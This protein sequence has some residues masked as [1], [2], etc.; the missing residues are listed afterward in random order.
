MA[1]HVRIQMIE[2][3]NRADRSR[4]HIA[5]TF[6]AFTAD[7]AP[8]IIAVARDEIDFF[9]AITDV[10]HPECSGGAVEARAERIAE[11]HCVNL[12]TWVT[13]VRSFCAKLRAVF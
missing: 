5:F 2:V 10:S 6:D 1:R 12:G 11:T 13:C 9:D 4:R 7:S 8:T 3:R